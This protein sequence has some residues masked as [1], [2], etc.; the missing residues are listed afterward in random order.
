[1]HNGDI[2]TVTILGATGSIGCATL[3]IVRDQRG[4]LGYDSIKILALTAQ[5]N[6]QKLAE[7]AC[8]FQPEFVA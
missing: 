5:N 4:R 6:W 2:K 8:E 3:E 1:M 7:L